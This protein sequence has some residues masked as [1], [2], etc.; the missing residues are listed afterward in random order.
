L[1]CCSRVQSG[2]PPG[3]VRWRT[4]ATATHQSTTIDVGEPGR[5]VERAAEIFARGE[6]GEVPPQAIANLRMAIELTLIVV[7][8][9]NRHHAERAVA[10][11]FFIRTQAKL[12]HVADAADVLRS[13]RERLDELF[14]SGIEICWP[15]TICERRSRAH[16]VWSPC[17]GA[18]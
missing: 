11:E 13:A 8:G 17:D 3:V 16:L 6:R 2:S 1:P 10:D 4:V 14:R 12:E 7:P 15:R 18:V 9:C 5:E